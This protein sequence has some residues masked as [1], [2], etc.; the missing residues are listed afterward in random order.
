MPVPDIDLADQ[1]QELKDTP[2][3][4]NGL[5]PED[6]DHDSADETAPDTSTPASPDGAFGQQRE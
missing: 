1:L 6:G 5:Q 3:T 2:P 4:A